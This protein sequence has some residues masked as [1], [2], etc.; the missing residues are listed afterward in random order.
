MTH[1]MFSKSSMLCTA[2]TFLMFLQASA[3]VRA[4][5]PAWKSQDI[6][7]VVGSPNA[8]LHSVPIRVVKMGDGSWQTRMKVSK[9]RSIPALL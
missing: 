4:E 8:K 9:E 3:A 5:E 6:I 1:R 7:N 2:A